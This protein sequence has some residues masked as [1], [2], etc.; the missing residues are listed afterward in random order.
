MVLGNIWKL[1]ERHDHEAIQKI[2]LDR[3]KTKLKK[4]FIRRWGKQFSNNTGKIIKKFIQNQIRIA[5]KKGSAKLT[6]EEMKIGVINFL[7]HQLDMPEKRYK[8]LYGL[9]KSGNLVGEYKNLYAR[10]LATEQ[11]RKDLNELMAKK[12]LEKQTKIRRL[13]GNQSTSP[14]P[15]KIQKVS[16]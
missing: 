1:I 3:N 10:H 8:K 5:R 15:Q 2:Y 16:T 6:H 7:R 12:T 13:R 9:A 4:Q 14:T 11:I